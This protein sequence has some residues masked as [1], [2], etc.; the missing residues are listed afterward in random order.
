MTQGLLPERV[1]A[2]MTPEAVIP[3]ALFLVSDDSPKRTI[4]SAVAGGFS[5]IVIQETAGVFLPEGERTPEAIAARYAEISDLS[6]VS[7]CEE[8]GGPGLRFVKMA[9]E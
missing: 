4:L 5:R 2:L 8:P 6:T 9:S 1:L 3:A 7:H